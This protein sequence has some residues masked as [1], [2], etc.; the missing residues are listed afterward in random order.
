MKLIN[1]NLFV[2][3]TD[4]EVGK[5]YITC[6]ILQQFKERNLKAVGLKPISS[7]HIKIEGNF[8]NED[9]YLLAKN[10][11]SNLSAADINPFTFPEFIAPHIAAKKHGVELTV[12]KI[13][14]NMQ[15]ESF[16]DYEHIIVE[17]AGGWLVPLNEQE[18]IADLAKEINFPVL[19][20]V[21]IK[22]GCIN[23]ALLTYNKIKEMGLD[24]YGWVANQIEPIDETEKQENIS[25]I[26][27]FIDAPLINLITISASL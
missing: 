19:I 13:Y 2:T 25:I 15:L 14:K 3:G 7:G 21:N 4:T 23:H 11:S 26:S 1:S 24:V 9:A 6:K 10:S 8:V 12:D 22:L 5:T 20:V 16:N 27:N 17:G 18:T